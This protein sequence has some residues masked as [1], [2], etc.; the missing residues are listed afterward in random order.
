MLNQS[1][2]TRGHHAT[3]LETAT[4]ISY[5]Y[6][7]F[8]ASFGDLIWWFLSVF[9]FVSYLFVLFAV[10][11]DIFRDRS[12]KGGWKTLWIILLIFLP[13]VTALVYLIARGRGMSERSHAQVQHL[14]DQQSEY[15]RSL[16]EPTTPAGEIAK[17]KALLDAG[18]ISDEEFAYLKTK[19]LS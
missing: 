17:A 8:W 2:Q 12:L 13:L 4:P 15:V 7:G 19:A 14:R 6:Q 11:G 18:T 16:V 5:E 9:I 3:P 1:P 10:I